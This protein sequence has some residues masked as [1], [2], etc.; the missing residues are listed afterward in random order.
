MPLVL[1]KIPKKSE[2]VFNQKIHLFF[3]AICCEPI[4]QI[5]DALLNNPTC[6]TGM[7]PTAV[8]GTLTSAVIISSFKHFFKYLLKVIIGIPKSLE[9]SLKERLSCLTAFTAL[10][11][12]SGGLSPLGFLFIGSHDSLRVL[13][14]CTYL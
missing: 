2:K 12:T 1:L 9:V 8:V 10:S 13:R 3:V 5:L 11:I 6:L 7:Y 4:F 14:Y